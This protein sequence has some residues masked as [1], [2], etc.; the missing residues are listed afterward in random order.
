MNQQSTY[1]VADKLKLKLMGL[2]R[3]DPATCITPTSNLA[4]ALYKGTESFLFS[5][6]PSVYSII[7][8]ATLRS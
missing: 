3:C 8:P 1:Q 4:S 2:L 6:N 7:I 5:L